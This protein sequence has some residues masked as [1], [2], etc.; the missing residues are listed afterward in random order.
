VVKWRSGSR[1]PAEDQGAGRTA[2]ATAA[3]PL[4]DGSE[5]S[6]PVPRAG[7]ALIGH[8]SGTKLGDLLIE[9][10]TLTREQLDAALLEQTQSGQRLGEIFLE[11]GFL[12][13]QELLRTLSKQ[14]DLP[15]IDLRR[16][17]PTE[18]ALAALPEDVVRARHA[19]PMRVAKE[20]LAVA[21][22]GPP[23]A[24]VLAELEHAA[25]SRVSVVLAPTADI[26][27]LIDR[28]YRA[29]AGMDRI[30]QSYRGDRG[31]AEAGPLQLD[32]NAPVVQ[33]VQRILTEAVRE[34]ASDVHVEPQNAN[35][36]V[37]FRI[38][39]ALHD[40]VTLPAGM[41]Q[42]LVSRIKIMADLN[43]V[44]RRR[45]QDGQFEVK[46]DGRTLDVRVAT[47]ATIWGADVAGLTV[48]AP[49]TVSPTFTG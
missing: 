34:R 41:A 20:G 23:S 35:L 31:G 12:N 5:V 9:L 21:M 14:L 27:R 15:M 47:T 7:V 6:S 13:E 36:R 45:P 11:L 22:P 37:R 18:E 2:T 49:V 8:H 25:G 3:P 17:L 44:E 4:G 46:V 32:D 24:D 1:D 33:V 26:R 16:N 29:T 38:D 30:V 42:A 48:T 40:A 28:S 39:G 19:L 43:I 10:G